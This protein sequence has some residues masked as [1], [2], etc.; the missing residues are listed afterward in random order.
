MAAI[1]A[2]SAE[3]LQVG[4]FLLLLRQRGET[5]AELAGFVAAARDRLTIDQD[6][7]RVDLDWPS[8]ADR[9]RQQPWFAL[10]ALLLARNGLRILMHGVEGAAE[11]HAPTRPVLA[12]LGVPICTSTAQVAAAIGRGNI[13]YVGLEHMAPDVARLL[14]LR[15]KL[16]VRTVANSFA[17]ALN[18]LRAPAQLQGV[19]HPPYRTLHCE[20]ALLIGQPRAAVFKGGAGEAQRNPLKPCQVSWLRDGASGD[21]EWPALLPDDAYAWRDED[22][23]PDAAVALWRGEIAL[24]APAAAVTGT[25]AIALKLTGRAATMSEAQALAETMWRGRAATRRRAV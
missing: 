3:P 1:L 18:P 14:D 15:A 11:G 23:R 17:R 5:A 22:L 7:A 24:P 16:G 12:A 9:H 19:F 21:E 13:A 6:A 2:G 4:G 20:A 8:Y 10:A 25:A